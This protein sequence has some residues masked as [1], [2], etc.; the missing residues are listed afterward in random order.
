MPNRESVTVLLILLVAALVGC[1]I[2]FYGVAVRDVCTGAGLGQTLANVVALLACSP[3]L[4]AL[5]SIDA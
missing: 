5:Y 2:Y 4:A 3:V 1:T